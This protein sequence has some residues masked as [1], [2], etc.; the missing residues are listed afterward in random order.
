M[1]R[2]SLHYRVEKV[3]LSVEE[4]EVWI[5]ETVGHPLSEEVVSTIREIFALTET[6]E[7]S[8]IYTKKVF[9]CSNR[10]G[11]TIDLTDVAELPKGFRVLATIYPALLNGKTGKLAY[12]YP[13]QFETGRI[14]VRVVRL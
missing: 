9:R 6:A 13:E 5:E 1:I 14:R 7:E 10:K 12:I 3:V 11:E 8:D 2:I 4:A